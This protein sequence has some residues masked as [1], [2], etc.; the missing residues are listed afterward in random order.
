MT[1]TRKLIA[2]NGVTRTFEV[3]LDGTMIGTDEEPVTPPPLDP[4]GA[5]MTLLVMKG[6]LTTEEAADAIGLQPE[7]L[8]AEA[9][10]WAV[11]TGL[12]SGA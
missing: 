5:A 8:V 1:T 12:A 3:Y 6:V 4:L 2:D 10:A 7:Q 9:E 11:A